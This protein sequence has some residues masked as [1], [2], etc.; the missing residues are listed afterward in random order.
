MYGEA[1]SA[2]IIDSFSDSS[3]SSSVKELAR[4]LLE[5]HSW[6]RL[7]EEN[8]GISFTKIEFNIAVA[9]EFC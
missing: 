6:S 1:F 7:M 5:K 2:K 4:K 8:C 3:P 9:L